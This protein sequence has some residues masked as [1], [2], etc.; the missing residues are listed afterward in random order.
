MNHSSI[1]LHIFDR[2]FRSFTKSQISDEV[3]CKTV[4]IASLLSN[5][6]YAG[7]AN[8]MESQPELPKA[9]EFL[10]EL[11]KLHEAAIVSSSSYPDEFIEGRRKLYYVDKERYPMYFESDS[12]LLLPKYA[13]PMQGSTTTIL[14]DHLLD[15]LKDEKAPR[16]IENAVEIR[17][18]IRNREDGG[19]TLG[20]LGRHVSIT[21]VEHRWL[22][23]HISKTY[24][25][26]YMDVLDGCLIKSIPDTSVA[27][28]SISDGYYYF[29]IYYTFF[30]NVLFRFL[31]WGKGV[32]AIVEHLVLFKQ[33][34]YYWDMVNY[35][36]KIVNS[37][38]VF[39][40][41]KST[42]G[43]E[44][45]VATK[46]LDLLKRQ[47]FP[48]FARINDCNINQYLGILHKS[49]QD[50]EEKEKIHLVMNQEE[51]TK[52]VLYL[53][54]T[55]TEYRKVFD[56][57]KGKNGFSPNSFEVGEYSYRDLGLVGNSHIYLL[58][59]GIGAKGN[60]GSILAVHEAEQSLKP[61]YVIM[62]GI[63][64]GLDEEKQKIGDIMV[65][66]AIEDYGTV[67]KLFRKIIKRGNRIPSSP[68]L[69]NR[70]S[71]SKLEWAKSAVHCGL[72]VTNDILVNDKSFVSFLKKNYP[73][74]IGGEME[75]CG[76]LANYS[77]PWILVKAICDFGH[78]KGDEHQVDAAQNA[79]EYVDITLEKHLL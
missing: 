51:N 15:A 74:A 19:I 37:L 16:S 59:T 62:V 65:S 50:I 3:A 73:D 67:K 7:M 28:D 31:N 61:D 22:G 5:I 76:L 12:G 14:E 25:K 54:A 77:T 66:T 1:Y 49:V 30:Y 34:D 46:C 23:Q 45:S 47:V 52:K 11:E 64:F 27:L 18:A 70:F 32:P 17:K 48:K 13:M 29:D 58:K 4:A 75:G 9:V 55:E 44:L 53:V 2:E 79:I 41:E 72:I 24:T 71:D 26:R 69:M 10:C 8:L 39:F 43:N 21:P 57:Y 60:G 63:G 78:D 6:P 42:L 38:F 56:Y 33:S 68:I 35:Y 36:N 20:I 40:G